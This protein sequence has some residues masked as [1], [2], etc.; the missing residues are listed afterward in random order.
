MSN[1]QIKNGNITLKG[2]SLS[3]WHFKNW[4]VCLQICYLFSFNLLLRFLYLLRIL[5]WPFPFIP[6]FYSIIFSSS[7]LY[8]QAFPFHWIFCCQLKSLLI[9]VIYLK[10]K[11]QSTTHYLTVN[12]SSY[13]PNAFPFQP[14]SLQYK[15]ASLGHFVTSKIC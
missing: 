11:Y 15:L 6:G 4:P 12:F 10:L 8:L 5:I 7:L 1:G 14:I 13:S 9:F 2:N 3:R